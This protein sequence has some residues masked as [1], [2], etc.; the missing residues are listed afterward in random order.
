[1]SEWFILQ[2]SVLW[3]RLHQ[4]MLGL[5]VLSFLTGCSFTK[6]SDE[7]LQDLEY[8]ILAEQEIP[9]EFLA[10]LEGKKN[11]PM[12]LTYLDEGGL[13]LA[14]GYGTQKTTGYSIG[15]EALYLTETDICV[16]TT[17]IGPAPGETVTEVES[18]P[19]IVLRLDRRE[20]PV[21]FR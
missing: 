15:V 10:I 8:T 20:E 7:K 12:N 21:V 17:L 6:Q 16:D 5:L 9:E 1:M 19:Y 14:V 3:K 4:C 2:R 11:N 18:Y 13:Y